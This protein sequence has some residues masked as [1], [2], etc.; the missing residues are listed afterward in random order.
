MFINNEIK[1][2]LE[3]LS[4]EE[5]NKK[6]FDCENEP[7]RWTSLNNGI[8]LCHECSEEHKNFEIGTNVIKSISLEQWNKNQLKIMK[9]GGNKKLKLF[10]ENYNVPKNIG[11]KELY[12]SKLMVYYRKKLKAEAEE[13]LLIDQLPPKEEFWDSYQDNNINI[14]NN[15]SQS[16]NI[17]VN[18]NINSINNNENQINNNSE[19]NDNYISYDDDKENQFIND[20]LLDYPQSSIK[21]DE[22]QYNIA[23]EKKKLEEKMENSVLKRDSISSEEKDPK[24]SSFSSDNANTNDNTSIQSS[25]YIGT[26]GNILYS[27]WQTGVNATSSVKEKINEYQIGKSI[28]YIGGKVYEGVIYIGGKIF[29]KG[30]DLIYSESAQ[31][32]VNKAISMAHRITGSEDNSNNNNDNY[33]DIS[34]ENDNKN[35]NNNKINNTDFDNNYGILNDQNENLLV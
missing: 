27:V 18:L 12:N 7:A 22:V 9:A 32:I 17:N 6:C 23:K 25:G 30:T 20:H 35:N 15:N 34:D 13:D 29:E 19:K 33:M 1:K 4:N 16:N 28:L 31:N 24:F 2:Q 5:D 26:V 11:K 21:I 10:L 8:Y 3:K 14:F